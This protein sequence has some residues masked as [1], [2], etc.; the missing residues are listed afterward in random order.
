MKCSICLLWNNKLQNPQT[1]KGSWNGCGNCWLCHTV[2][3]LRGATWQWILG[4]GWSS[5]LL[6]LCL[7][8]SGMIERSL[9]KQNWAHWNVTA[10]LAWKKG[11]VKYCLCAGLQ[12]VLCATS[13]QFVTGKL[14]VTSRA[15]IMLWK[16]KLNLIVLLLLAVRYVWDNKSHN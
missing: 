10:M 14:L 12:C 4:N 2:W 3:L 9:T 11:T 16:M 7:L 8:G 1:S 15:K 5:E 6:R 13:R